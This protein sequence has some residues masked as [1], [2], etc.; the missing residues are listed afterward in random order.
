M[1][2]AKNK[3]SRTD[4]DISETQ[5]NVFSELAILTY[6]NQQALVKTYLEW[7]VIPPSIWFAMCMD[8]CRNYADSFIIVKKNLTKEKA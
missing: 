4:F 1:L 2:G 6:E 7:F 5:V 3:V 8:G